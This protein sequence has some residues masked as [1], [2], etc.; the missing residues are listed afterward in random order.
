MIDNTLPENVCTRSVCSHV[1]WSRQEIAS[2]PHV[3]TFRTVEYMISSK[4]YVVI[5]QM[6][7]LSY[8]IVTIKKRENSTQN[9]M[10]S[11]H[12]ASDGYKLHVWFSSLFSLEWNDIEPFALIKYKNILWTKKYCFYEKQ[13]RLAD[14]SSFEPHSTYESLNQSNAKLTN[15]RSDFKYRIRLI[16]FTRN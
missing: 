6:L 13:S 15:M 4:V 12:R 3:V 10:K 7:S 2:I 8:E 14:G 16:I 11:F 9:N 5:C 1:I